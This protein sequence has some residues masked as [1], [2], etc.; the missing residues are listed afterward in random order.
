MT[1]WTVYQKI[2]FIETNN[3]LKIHLITAIS[4]HTLSR[5]KNVK[6]FV[7]FMKNLNIQ[8]KKQESSVITDFKSVISIKYHDFLNVFSKNKVDVLSS[9]KKHNHRIEL[10]KE[11]IHEYALLY[12]M[13]EK[14]LLLMKK[15]L[16]KYLNKNFIEL[17]TASYASFILFAMKSDEEFRFCVNYRKLNAIIKKNRYFI[18]LIVEMIARLFKIK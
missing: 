3:V 18:S 17:S 7:V 11:K 4:S 10:K 2:D 14:E 1:K 15:Y 13:S 9:H 6:I 8:L 16:Q 12:N 5:Q